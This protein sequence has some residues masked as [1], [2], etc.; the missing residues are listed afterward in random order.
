L[1]YHLLVFIVEGNKFLDKSIV[2][3]IFLEIIRSIP[4]EF[5]SCHLLLLGLFSFLK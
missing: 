4:V 1:I 2:L 3:E 5:L